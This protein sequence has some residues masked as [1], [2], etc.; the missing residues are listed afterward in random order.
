MYQS[1][2]GLYD[3]NNQKDR[4]TCIETIEVMTDTSRVYH[5]LSRFFN[6]RRDGGI[7]IFM[8]K[9]CVLFTQRGSYFV[10]ITCNLV[11][12]TLLSNEK[13]SLHTHFSLYIKIL[14]SNL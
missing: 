9:I 7:C 6:G 11:T 1:N 5:M 12:D 3:K 13:Q 8:E 4:I 10:S 2:P 14:G